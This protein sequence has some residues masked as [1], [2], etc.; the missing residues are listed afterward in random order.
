VFVLADSDA[1]D[2]AFW[3]RVAER[4]VD[5]TTAYTGGG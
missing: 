3:T 2:L 1:A 4:V 5:L